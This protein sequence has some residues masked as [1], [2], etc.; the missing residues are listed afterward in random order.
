[1]DEAL[2][3]VRLRLTRVNPDF[4]S[5]LVQA[6]P[7][8]PD[9]RLFRAVE[10]EWKLDGATGRGYSDV[11]L[12]VPERY[13]RFWTMQAAGRMTIEEMAARWTMDRATHELMRR[14]RLIPF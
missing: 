5:L 12:V 4:A 1:M 14:D 7:Y 2:Q 8:A 13:V 10:S 9:L 3:V 11:T 6:Q